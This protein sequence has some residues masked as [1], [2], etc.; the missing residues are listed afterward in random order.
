MSDRDDLSHYIPRHLDDAPKFLFW[1]L[2]IAGVCLMGILVGI[3]TGFPILGVGLGVGVAFLYSK[4]K[5]GKHPGMAT[6]LLYWLTGFPE[7]KELPRS[8]LRELNG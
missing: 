1:E 8:H 2:D 6:H 4:L 5:A 3:A 7:P